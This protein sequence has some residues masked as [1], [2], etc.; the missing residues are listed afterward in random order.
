MAIEML[1]A[2][3]A[4]AMKERIISR[5]DRL[6]QEG[7]IPCLTIIRIGERP[8]DLSYE[9]GAKKRMELTGIE[10]RVKELPEDISQEEFEGE[11]RKVNADETVHGILLFRP[12][13]AHL[14]EKP[15]RKMINPY[16]DVDCMSDVNLAKVFAGD[17]SGFAPCTAEAVMEMLE[18]YGIDVCG[19]KVTVVGRSMVVGR[20]LAMLM[21]QK[22]A[23]V[24]VC[25]TRTAELAETCRNADIL[26]A[27]AG[28][29]KMITSDMIGEGAIVA[30]VGINA[31][32]EGK[33]CGDVDYEGA[34]EKASFI[35]PVPRGVGSVTTSVL[36]LHVIKAAE[37][38]AHLE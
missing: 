36:A 23:T 17:Q 25:H 7:I 29:A 32:A 10:C 3:V 35:S 28:R 12:L 22:N 27:A 38:L 15:V 5:G 31:D 19:K 21:L 37:Y 1:G 4:K 30:D 8:D 6:K 18:H 33:M 14:D 13:P 2:E 26:V 9:R 11:F 16:K 24:T 34:L 20:P